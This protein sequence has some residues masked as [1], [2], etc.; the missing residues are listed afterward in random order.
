MTDLGTVVVACL[1]VNLLTFS[2]VALM[3]G[4]SVFSSTAGKPLAHWVTGGINGFAA[5]A[6][7]GSAAF[8]MMLESS[9]LVEE[10]WAGDENDVAWRWGFALLAGFL[11]PLIGQVVSEAAGLDFAGCL[12]GGGNGNAQK[13]AGGGS[14]QGTELVGQL[15]TS[16]D[17]VETASTPTYAPNLEAG[18]THSVSGDLDELGAT[19]AIV[20]SANSNSAVFAVCVGDFFHNFTDGVFIGAAFKLCG[21]KA[22]WAL[23]GAASAHELAQELADFVVLTSDSVGLSPLRALAVNFLTGTSIAL[24]GIIVT[25]IDINEG[26]LGLLLAAGAGS[27]IYLGAVV[28]LPMALAA[29]TAHEPHQQSNSSTTPT[30]SAS[31]RLRK[32]RMLVLFAFALGAIA[33]GLVLL[34]HEHCDEEHGHE[35]EEDEHHD[36]EEEEGHE[37]H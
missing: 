33:I 18:G 26:A 12:K 36:E 7:L 21:T 24:G 13:G 32:H 30:M 27:Y 5:G 29:A 16:L 34:N 4:F 9:H 1:L 8:L 23:A 35:E 20:A 25:E 10:E 14:N 28:S 15:G 6:L 22:G 19:A 3:G 37:D 11:F 31:A 17:K 2:G